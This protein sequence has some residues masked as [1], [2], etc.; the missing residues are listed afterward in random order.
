MGIFLDPTGLF[1]YS[2]YYNYEYIGLEDYT[3]EYLLLKYNTCTYYKIVYVPYFYFELKW[4]ELQQCSSVLLLSY[5]VSVA[6]LA[7][8]Y[9]PS[10]HPLLRLLTPYSPLLSHVLTLAYNN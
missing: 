8:R 2:E 4:S 1:G 10:S 3:S 9:S 5:L 7:R 6:A